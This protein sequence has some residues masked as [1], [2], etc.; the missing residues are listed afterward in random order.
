M[1]RRN[2]DASL[3]RADKQAAADEARA[4]AGLVSF[5]GTAPEG[6]AGARLD[7]RIVTAE[8]KLASITNSERSR[9]GNPAWYS[10]E[11]AF[12]IIG[13]LLPQSAPLDAR[14]VA[15][16]LT[17]VPDFLRDARARLAEAGA[18]PAGWCDRARRES[19]AMA[20][21][22][23]VDLARFAGLAQSWAVPAQM[24]AVA[25]K[26]FAKSL[27]SL[28]DADPA[29]GSRYLEL[30][31]REV[32]G[33]NAGTESIL[34]E[35]S[36]AFERL[37]AELVADAARLAPGQTW[38][39][40]IE[41]LAEIT[42]TVPGVLS[43]YQHWHDSAMTAAAQAGLVTPAREYALDYRFL[44]MPYL[45]VAAETYFLFYRSPPALR[46]G[47]GSVYWV[48]P[49]GDNTPSYLRAQNLSTI[50]TTHTVHHGSIGHHTQNANARRAP[51]LL[52]K[53][54]G[55]DCASGIAFLSAGTMVE[56][57]A[58]Y[59]EDLLREAG[60]FYSDAELLLLKQNERRNAASV[61]VDINLHLRRW[62]V[63]QAAEFYRVEAGFPAHRAG[64][65]TVRNSMFPGSRLMYWAGVQAIRALRR[66]SRLGTRQFHDA[67]LSYGHVPISV[68]AGEMA[69]AD[70]AR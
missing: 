64:P 22:L 3:P 68:A 15:A 13:L 53:V 12:S 27:D 36:A 35:A 70:R 30:V 9:F 52:A 42:P 21:F 5:A 58:C 11:V 54:A 37:S 33:L 41:S 48:L 66:A 62:S 45:R 63:T 1:G 31:I 2:C 39:Q 69:R 32:H 65:E 28:A 20:R 7:K 43:A 29:A 57:W 59:A 47:D 26:E 38:Q 18:A 56:G 23:K 14:A 19:L 55:T 10:G 67:L 6:D 44:E 24:A 34:A 16:R 8:L 40:V 50:K 61:M 49:P 4:I 46:P 60:G 17:A 51:G 25:L